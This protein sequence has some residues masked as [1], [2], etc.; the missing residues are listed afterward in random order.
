MYRGSGGLW[1]RFFFFEFREP[2]FEWILLWRGVRSQGSGRKYSDFR[3]DDTGLRGGH[4][5][6]RLSAHKADI[7]SSHDRCDR[8]SQHRGRIYLSH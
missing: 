3:C 7:N 4:D 5:G 6:E 1:R 8:C 2:E